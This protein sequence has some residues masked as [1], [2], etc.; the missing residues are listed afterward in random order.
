[1]GVCA[2]RWSYPAGWLGRAGC[3][4][5]VVRGSS[6]RNTTYNSSRARVWLRDTAVI[7]WPLSSGNA[8]PQ[9]GRHH[10]PGERFSDADLGV[11]V[12]SRGAPSLSVA[13]LPEFSALGPGCIRLLGGPRISK[14]KSC[15]RNLYS[16]V[17]GAR[18]RSWGY[19]PCGDSVAPPDRDVGDMGKLLLRSTMLRALL[20]GRLR[21]RRF[22]RGPGR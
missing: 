13:C 9:G 8:C 12:R 15:S 11:A 2:D 19:P 17:G 16:R 10:G 14:T 3:A 5:R 22:C 4:L 6:T 7:E 21:A 20:G 1:V 18:S